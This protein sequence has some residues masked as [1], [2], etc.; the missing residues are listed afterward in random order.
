MFALPH[1]AITSNVCVPNEV[2]D[3]ETTDLISPRM[4]VLV[5]LDLIEIVTGLDL[6][7]DTRRERPWRADTSR[8]HV[9][10]HRMDA[11]LYAACGSQFQNQLR[12]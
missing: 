3:K 7:A 8:T 12:G 2:E 11:I 10:K 9:S 4:D 1:P 6:V 5:H